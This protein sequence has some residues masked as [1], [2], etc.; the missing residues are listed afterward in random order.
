VQHCEESY[1][2]QIKEAIDSERASLADTMQKQVCALFHYLV[3]WPFFLQLLFNYF[4][5]KVK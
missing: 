3:K 2:Q 4:F 5:I 1:K